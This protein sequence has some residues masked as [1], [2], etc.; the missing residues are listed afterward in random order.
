VLRRL[1]AANAAADACQS[2]DCS[3]ARTK[4]TCAEDLGGARPQRGRPPVALY[5]D[6]R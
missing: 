3:I 4:E 2:I 6:A 5:G 1:V